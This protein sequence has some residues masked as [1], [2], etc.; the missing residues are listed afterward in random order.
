M[1]GLMHLQA[2]RDL[3]RK[4]IYRFN[5][6]L[7]RNISCNSLLIEDDETATCKCLVDSSFKI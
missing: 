2:K 3:R 7:K 5:N 4:T 1:V 6:G